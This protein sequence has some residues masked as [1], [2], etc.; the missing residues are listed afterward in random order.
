[1]TG[2]AESRLRLAGLCPIRGLLGSACCK[3][4]RAITPRSL[5]MRIQ[6]RSSRQGC[7]LAKAEFGKYRGV[8]IYLAT[9][10]PLTVNPDSSP[11]EEQFVGFGGP[12]QIGFS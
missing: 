8:C 12:S 11:F 2:R 1:M 7:T 3:Q 9:R 10:H 5:V 6:L 4:A